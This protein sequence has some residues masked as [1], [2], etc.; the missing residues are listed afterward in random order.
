M[1]KII[2]KDNEKEDKEDIKEETNSKSNK[3]NKNE[4]SYV[5]V[6][7][8]KQSKTNR[9]RLFSRDVNK[10]PFSCSPN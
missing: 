10:L 4:S 2:L 6:S 3:K 1:L 9:P 8:C 5:V 7:K